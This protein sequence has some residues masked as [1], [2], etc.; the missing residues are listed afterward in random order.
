MR[1]EKAS[2]VFI[3]KSPP[4]SPRGGITIGIDFGGHLEPLLHPERG[5]Q[6]SRAASDITQNSHHGESSLGALVYRELVG[7]GCTSKGVAKPCYKGGMGQ[8]ARDFENRQMYPFNSSYWL[9]RARHWYEPASPYRSRGPF[10]TP[11]S[12]RMWGK[13]TRARRRWS[14]YGRRTTVKA[15]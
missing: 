2:A 12:P 15:V 11:A 6:C 10:R 9:E 4:R 8:K 1:H 7:D 14:E 5:R 13:Q 3:L